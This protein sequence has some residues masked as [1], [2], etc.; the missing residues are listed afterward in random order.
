M[1][2]HYLSDETIAEF[3]PEVTTPAGREDLRR[4]FDALMAQMR[5]VWHR[6][7]PRHHEL[8]ATISAD[9]AQALPQRIAELEA[10]LAGLPDHWRQY[11]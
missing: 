6:S 9:K 4:Q 7:F 2:R 1:T 5:K 10:A 11:Q 8:F 3:W